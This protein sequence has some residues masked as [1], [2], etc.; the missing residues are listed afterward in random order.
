VKYTLIRS[1]VL[2]AIL[3]T[4]ALSVSAAAQTTGAKGSRDSKGQDDAKLRDSQRQKAEKEAKRY[5]KVKAFSLNLYQTDADFHDQVDDDYDAVQREHSIEAFEKNVA[6]PARPTLVHDG[7]RLRLQ[8]GL[9]DNK[10]VADYVNH[11]GQQ[12]V[13]VDSDKLFAF[14]LVADPTPFADTLSTGTIYIST[15]LVSLLDNEAQLAFVLAHE[16]AHVQLDHWRLKSIL[17][18]G[19]EEYNKNQANRRK[20]IGTGLGALAGA[21]TGKAVGN[22]AQAVVGGGV[23]GAAIGYAIGSVWARALTLDWDTVQEDEAD[24]VAFKVALSHSYDVREVPKLYGTLQAAVRQD[25]R[26]GLGFVGNKRRIA[27]RLANSQ[28]ALKDLKTF[29]DAQPNKLVVTNPEFVR[30]MSALKRDN[31]IL[32][33]Y[34]DMFQLAKSNL[35]YA[36]SNRPND[37][38]AHYYYGKVMKLV[39]RTPEDQKIADE[40]FQRAIQFDV[41]ER[42]YGAY[43]YRALALIDQRNPSLNPEIAKALQSYLMASIRFASDEAS[44]ANVLPPNLDDLYDYLTEAGEVKWRP[45]VPDEL[46]GALMKVSADTQKTESPL[47]QSAAPAPRPAAS[48]PPAAPASVPAKK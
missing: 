43:F 36:R 46:K 2:P 47:R 21:L 13:P 15:G 1:I 31:G 26:V 45:I 24:A 16:M 5:D 23:A 34:H 12:L 32:A 17:K 37:P 44:L 40:A 22:D 41:R 18:F 4:T 27:E 20:L 9:Y 11:V 29:V 30:V 42:N 39:G 38:A 28:D 10:M 19:D 6:P 25:S 3:I 7:D 8:I 35:E 48:T 14:R 33:F